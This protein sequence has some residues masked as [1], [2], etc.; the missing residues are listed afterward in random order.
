MTKVTNEI[1]DTILIST[2]CTAGCSHCPFS[3]S[4]IEHLFLSQKKINHI[5]N[6]SSNSLSVLSGGEPF[7]HPEIGVI[8]LEL[9]NQP[10]PFRIATGGFIDLK[11]WLKILTKLCRQDGPL[12]GIS[13]GTDVLSSRVRHSNWVSVWK[14]NINMFLEFQIPF[15]L[16]F[17]I[18][19]SLN[20]SWFNIWEWTSHFESKPQFIYI[21]YTDNTLLDTW[22]EKIRQVFGLI[23]LIEDKF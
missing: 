14:E 5:L 3:N 8:L 1:A 13:M 11:P 2:K 21:R 17:T 22:V 9:Y 23:D 10:K 16:T 4:A 19:D 20:F 12:L 18:D 6:A 15:S 7:E